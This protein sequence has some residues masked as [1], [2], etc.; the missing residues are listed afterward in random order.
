[1]AKYL[2][3]VTGFTT[4]SFIPAGATR[5]NSKHKASEPISKPKLGQGI[6]PSL[7]LSLKRQ[8]DQTAWACTYS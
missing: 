4:E 6:T 3:D 7:P 2:S 8:Q 5:R 1:M